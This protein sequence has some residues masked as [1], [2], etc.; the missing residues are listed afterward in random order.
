ME[1]SSNLTISERCWQ[2]ANRDVLWGWKR[3]CGPEQR[4]ILFGASIISDANGKL[5]LDD[6]FLF[7]RNRS[8]AEDIATVSKLL[9]GDHIKRQ[10]G[11]VTNWICSRTGLSVVELAGGP[12]LARSKPLLRRLLNRRPR[13]EIPTGSFPTPT[14]SPLELSDCGPIAAY[15]GSG[16]SYEAGLPTLASVHETFGVDR[17]GDDN[18]IF[19]ARDP[20]P[21]QLAESVHDTFSRFVH[22]HVLAAT[23]RPSASHQR[24][25]SFYRKGAITKILTD[26][27][28]SLFAKVDVPF[29]RTRGIGIFNDRFETKFD[30][31]ERTLLVIGVAADRRD[32]IRQARTLGLRIV[33]VNP[34]APVSPRSQSLSYFC[35]KD[36]W[37]RMSAEEFFAR[38]VHE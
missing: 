17:L 28:D 30:R 9:D 37:Y 20:I 31:D 34:Q 35:Q 19:G 27:V 16:L 13:K 2:K 6:W 18:F 33:V 3:D 25:A 38:Y 22:F 21:E 8:W 36:R 10:V 24:L 7:Y 32:I 23:S 1:I 4:T 5:R 14:L 26:N 15:V 12:G 29:T 11:S